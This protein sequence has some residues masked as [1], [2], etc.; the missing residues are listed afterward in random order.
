MLLQTMKNEK[1]TPR[2]NFVR[3]ITFLREQQGLSKSDVSVDLNISWKR[4][5]QWERGNGTPGYNLLV[6]VARYFNRTVD[7][8]LTVDLTT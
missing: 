6:E 4:Y 8:L 2:A 3:N 5:Q 1:M 7:E